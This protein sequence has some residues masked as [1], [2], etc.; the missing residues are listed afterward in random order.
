MRE[1]LLEW[2]E[3][4]IPDY[5]TRDLDLSTLFGK[6]R[7][8]GVL[9]GCR[10]SG[11]TY[12][13]YQMIDDL[14]K[15]QKIAR[16]KIFYIS[17]ED[18]RIP[19]TTDTLTKLLPT[20]YELYG[21]QEYYL[22]LDEIHHIP[23]WDRWVRRLYDR[24][25]NIHIVLAS[26]S[27]K[28]SKKEIPEALRGRTAVMEVFPLSFWEF[29]RFKG[30]PNLDPARAT[31]LKLA[32]Y[33]AHFK[34]FLEYG[35]FP[36]VALESTKRRKIMIIQDYFRTIIALDIAERYSIKNVRALH[37]YIQLILTQT[38]HS[39]SKMH[40][41]LKGQGMNIGKEMILA[42]PHY[43]EEVYVV[44]FVS[45]FSTKVKDRLYYPQKVYFIDNS[46]IHHISTKFSDD[47]GRGLENL[48]FLHLFRTRGRDDIFYWK[49]KNKEAGSGLEVDF[50]LLKDK[51]AQSLI[52]VC[53][54]ISD[55][56]TKRR[57]L[58][59]L[60]MA[61]LELGCDNLIIITLDHDGVEEIN[62]KKIT[63]I[64]FLNWSHEKFED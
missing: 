34:E 7:K 11:K 46:F 50:V 29:L 61:S 21:E 25:Q 28:L 60:E 15:K 53:L 18:E 63:V 16:E 30:V 37:D 42:Y 22:F 59:G 9:T 17:F 2:Q 27:S 38:Y 44:F 48:V 51:K 55:E 47:L 64:P 3:L 56:K 40:K 6:V 43:L 45:I 57:E 35:G 26:S 41:I 36:E 62:G 20:L 58:E 33:M 5:I 32:E 4:G 1:L 52:Q 13:M 14:S 10:R 54:D 49:E 39:T 12:I 24:H 8:V 19:W 31:Q 23:G